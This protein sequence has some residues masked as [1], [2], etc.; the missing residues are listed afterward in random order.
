MRLFLKAKT[1]NYSVPFRPLKAHERFIGKGQAQ[2][3]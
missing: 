2:N 1:E 3:L